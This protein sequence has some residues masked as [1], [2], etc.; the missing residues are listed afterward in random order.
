MLRTVLADVGLSFW[1]LG[2]WNAC[3]SLQGPSWLLTEPMPRIVPACYPHAVATRR[4]K[5]AVSLIA[6]RSFHRGIWRFGLS[7]ASC[8]DIGLW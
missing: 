2:D 1:V 4:C 7:R 3:W 5:L 6:G 8:D